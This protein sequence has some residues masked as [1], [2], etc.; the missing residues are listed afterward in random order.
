M[1]TYRQYQVDAVSA[2]LKALKAGAACKTIISLPTGSGKSHVLCLL[3]EELIKLYTEEHNNPAP[4]VLVLSHNKE[5]LTQ[6][7]KIL[8]SHFAKSRTAIGLHSAGLGVRERE[9]IT[10]AGIQSIYKAD[11]WTPDIVIIDECHLV[12]RTGEGMYRSFLAHHPDA[13]LIGLTATPYRAKH[14]LLH[15]GEG[16]LFNAISFDMSNLVGFNQLVMDGYL[17][18]LLSRNAKDR[19]NVEGVKVVGGEYSVADLADRFDRDAIVKSAIKEVVAVGARYKT[20]L[21]FAIDIA[22]AENITEELRQHGISA[23]C[24]HSKTS[25]EERVQAIEDARRGNV[26]A[27][28]NV[29]ILTTG[30]DLPNIDLIVLLRPTMSPVLHVQMLGRGARVVYAPGY[31]TSTKEGRLDAINKGPKPFC[32]VLDFAGNIERLGPINDIHVRAKG[33]GKKGGQFVKTCNACD[34]LC[35]PR[36]TV[37]PFCGAEFKFLQKI[38]TQSDR[39]NDAII[40]SRKKEVAD[41]WVPV[42]SV[43]YNMHKAAGT[44]KPSLRVTYKTSKGLL[45]ASYS[46]WVCYGR[47]GLMGRR[48][49]TWVRNRWRGHGSLPANLSEL[50]LNSNLLHTPTEVLISVNSDNGFPSVVDARFEW[51]KNIAA[52]Q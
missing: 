32:R 42:A 19:F 37:C 45:A 38:T 7:H 23:K 33:K 1:S 12:P 25:K 18:K 48:A 29:N 35:H 39:H 9:Q 17:S 30:V 34:T 27:L 21:I 15:K 2:T 44:G 52:S 5:I 14:G 3:I 46:E 20:W 36:V 41:Y 8:T 22:H 49:L 26:T 16:A 11:G 24:V 50:Y 40:S 51:N 4:S 43:E 13:R 28:V 47:P 6:D 10:V 31:D